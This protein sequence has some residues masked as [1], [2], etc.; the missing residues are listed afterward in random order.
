[1][2]VLVTGAAGFIGSYVSRALVWRGDDVVGID[3]FHEYYPKKCKEFNVDTTNMAA[4]KPANYFPESD[5]KP[6]YVKLE[7]FYSGK[8]AAKKGSYS[9]IEGDIV[10]YEFLKKLFAKKK[11]DAVVHLAAMAGVPLSIKEPRLYTVVNVDGTVNLLDLSKTYG[12]NKFVFA[13]SS[14]VY[15]NR[16]DKKVTEEDEIV[17]AVSPYGATKSSGEI[18]CYSASVVYGLN[19]V[20]DRIFGPIFGP[21]Q[22]P[23]GMLMQRAI[24]FTFNNKK[25]QIYGKKGLNSAKD[26]TY[27]DDQVDGIIK[28]LDHESHFDVFNIG[29]SNPQSIKQWFDAIEVTMKKPVPY[30]IVEV[31]KGDVAASANISKAKRIL[32]YNPHMRLEEGVHRQVEVFL[33]MPEWYKTLEKV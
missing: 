18:L 28:L 4:G 31:D 11:F 32:G 12:I 33:A 20:V 17:H 9:F 25:V 24:N 3:N 13:S 10:N 21:L 1:V 23:Y 19:V 5:V 14:S 26:S 8:K 27:I 22:R 29:T 30:E 6:I 16:D 2:R 7:S 15:G